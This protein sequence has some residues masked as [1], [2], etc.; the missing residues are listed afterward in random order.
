[1]VYYNYRH[2]NP[3]DG[4]WIGRDPIGVSR[5]YNVY[6]YVRNSTLNQYDRLGLAKTITT[7]KENCSIDIS[8]NI[9]IYPDEGSVI[10]DSTM[11]TKAQ[12]IKQSIESNWNGNKK[13]C[14][15]VNVTADVTPQKRRSRW[16]YRVLNSDEN[17]IAI[18][19][20]ADLRGRARVFL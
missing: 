18:K 4:R 6:D 1:M 9:V 20:D 15:D 19:S 8:L 2:Y 5:G 13:G 3:T 7:N 11:Q 12:I 14:C 10:N 16:L 17:N